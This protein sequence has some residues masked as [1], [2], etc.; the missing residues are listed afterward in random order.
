MPSNREQER[1]Y[2]YPGLSRGQID[3]IIDA[4]LA[5]V[6]DR[7]LGGKLDEAELTIGK[8]TDFYTRRWGLP[9]A[10]TR[11]AASS[12]SPARRSSPTG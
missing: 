10:I 6:R 12:L 11:R 4:L 7:D 2:G 5:T 9:P 3:L 1:E 8:L